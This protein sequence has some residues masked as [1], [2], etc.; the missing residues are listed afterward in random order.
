MEYKSILQNLRCKHKQILQIPKYKLAYMDFF[1][2]IFLF[3]HQK[4]YPVKAVKVSHHSQ[5][6][7]IRKASI[8]L[9]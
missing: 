1:H 9:V 3:S 5:T 4:T 6:S 8:A 2:E 7:D